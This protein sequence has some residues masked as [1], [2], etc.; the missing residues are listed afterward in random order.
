MHRTTPIRRYVI[1]RRRGGDGAAR[2][3]L[4]QVAGEPRAAWTT[5]PG[6]VR[7]TTPAARRAGR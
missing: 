1:V 3:S 4:E 2:W 6:A 7:P 5:A